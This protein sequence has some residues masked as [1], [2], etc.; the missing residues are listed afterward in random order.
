MFSAKHVPSPRGACI[1]REFPCRSCRTK[2]RPFLAPSHP[3]QRPHLRGC[4]LCLLRLHELGVPVAACPHCQTCGH[5]P[6]DAVSGSE[7]VR[8][9]QR[10]LS[11]CPPHCCD[12]SLP[13][14][15]PAWITVALL[16]RAT[17]PSKMRRRSR[18]IH[19]RCCHAPRMTRRQ[20]N[21]T[22]P[23]PCPAPCC[24]VQ[25]TLH[26]MLTTRMA[27]GIRSEACWMRRRPTI[28][29]RV[30]PRPPGGHGDAQQFATCT[31]YDNE[32]VSIVLLL[33]LVL[34]VEKERE[35]DGRRV[36]GLCAASPI[37]CSLCAVVV[38]WGMNWVRAGCGDWAD[39]AE[40][41]PGVGGG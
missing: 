10:R 30:T 11:L 36:V 14:S 17:R 24:S 32:P 31:W 9:T 33:V 22:T 34:P 29:P 16:R 8:S 39:A 38:V 7:P 20:R 3:V 41:E 19:R 12:S 27:T 26:S 15:A 4:V 1:L 25:P 40:E 5:R 23:A 37:C 18:S 13:G 6:C 35:R 2:A 28:R 21:L